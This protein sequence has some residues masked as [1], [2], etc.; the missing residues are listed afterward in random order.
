MINNNVIKFS[1]N[2]KKFNQIKQKKSQSNK[3]NLVNLKYY[4]DKLKI[5]EYNKKSKSQNQLIK[6]RNKKK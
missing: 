1:I 5:N 6:L 3:N 2:K 4:T